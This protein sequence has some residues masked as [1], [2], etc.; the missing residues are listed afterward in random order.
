MSTVDSIERTYGFGEKLQTVLP[1]DTVSTAAKSMANYRVGC[2]L[3]VNRDD[4]LIGIISERDILTKITAADRDARTISVEQVMTTSVFSCTPD[5]STD[6]AQAIMARHRIRHL[7]IVNGTKPI[8]MVSI[9]DVIV[10][11]LKAAQE[12]DKHQRG[13]LQQLEDTHPGITKMNTDDA[14]RIVI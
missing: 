4:D 6:E 11:Q 7:P 8:G 14:G 12:R 1:D 5:M 2:L 9:R 3:V 10:H 13:V